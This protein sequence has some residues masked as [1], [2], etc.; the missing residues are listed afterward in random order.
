[1]IHLLLAAIYLAFIGLGLPDSMLG[2]AWPTMQ[3]TFAVPV[4]SAGILSSIIAVGT[5]CSSLCS[6]R[7]I[8]RY[9]TGKVT[10]ISTAITATALLGFGC[11]PSFGM[12]CLLAVPYGLGAGSV[13]AALNGYVAL[14]Y[15][16]HHMSWLHCMWGLGA[17]T[18]PCVMGYALTVQTW[19]LGYY[20]I[21][22]IQAVVAVLLFCALPLWKRAFQQDAQRITTD[23]RALTLREVFRIRG[24]AANMLAFFFYCGI[25]NM[26]S[27]WAS[28][29]MVTH[30]GM[31]VEQ[32]AS[33]AAMYFVGIMSGR[34]LSGFIS[35]KCS[36]S[37][38]IYGGFALMGV[39]IVCMVLPLPDGATLLGLLLL[40]LGCAPIY[41]CII[42]STPTNFGAENAQALTGVQMA[43][44][45]TGTLVMPPLFGIVAQ[46]T[47]IAI[48]PWML[49][50]TLAV[51]AAA[52]GRMQRMRN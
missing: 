23:H 28:S 33:W 31:A 40:G 18:G 38:M 43:C 44:A 14:H 46:A 50:G 26:A 51:M 52:Y 21:F 9:G 20:I 42:H 25:E 39:G 17:L 24:S 45:Y 30:K 34:F 36:D 47:D 6:G 49:A 10:A 37:Q 4:S 29:Y 32:A 41:P 3:L 13:D 22:G 48:Y 19:R 15:K 1:M 8:Q 35:M 2:A 16:S 7:I 11:S 27:L 5:I 12:L